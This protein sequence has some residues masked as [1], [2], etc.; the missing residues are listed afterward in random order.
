MSY[1]LLLG[2]KERI[3]N[4]EVKEAT[5][6]YE[7]GNVYIGQVVEGF[8]HGKGVM[9]CLVDQ[10]F[11]YSPL[12]KE[13][14]YSRKILAGMSYCGNWKDGYP[15]GDGLIEMKIPLSEIS[16]DECLNEK[17]FGEAV[18]TMWTT[19]DLETNAYVNDEL[20]VDS[21]EGNYIT[22]K[23]HGLI[24]I[25]YRSYIDSSLLMQTKRKIME[26]SSSLDGPLAD[27][28]LK[29]KPPKK[30][31]LL[32]SDED[33]LKRKAIPKEQVNFCVLCGIKN[34]ALM[35]KK[36]AWRC[37][38]CAKILNNNIKAKYCIVCHSHKH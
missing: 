35:D 6:T 19:H 12:G 31:Y 16:N 25:F 10:Q 24:E 29:D 11:I 26:L 30:R 13:F 14:S 4:F 1:Y 38:T 28:T 27:L 22:K 2:L 7:N 17:R 5:I 18:I 3:L 33:F 20:N 34:Q 9:T 37:M 21:D 32:D 15:T 36:K 8:R 23:E